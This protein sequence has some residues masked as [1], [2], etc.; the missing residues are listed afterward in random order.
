MVGDMS[1]L[2]RERKKGLHTPSLRIY[3]KLSTRGLTKNLSLYDV[4]IIGTRNSFH[5]RY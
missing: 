3:H 2:A 5:R 4:K 1:M